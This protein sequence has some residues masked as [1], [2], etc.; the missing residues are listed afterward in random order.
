[1][2]G[3]TVRFIEIGGIDVIKKCQRE[4][5][6]RNFLKNLRTMK[7]STLLNTANICSNL[8]MI[9]ENV[10]SSVYLNELFQYQKL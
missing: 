6:N 8:S 3:S 1:M 10:F 7:N 4:M 5:F 2:L 9:T